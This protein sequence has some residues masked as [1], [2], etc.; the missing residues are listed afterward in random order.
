MSSTKVKVSQSQILQSLLSSK[1]MRLLRLRDI[2]TSRSWDHSLP[3]IT[4]LRSFTDRHNFDSDDSFFE[5]FEK[6]VN[7]G[8][9]YKILQNAGVFDKDNTVVLFGGCLLDIILKRQSVINDFDLRLVG[10]EY[11]ND[12]S[13]CI[14]KAKEFVTSVFSYLSKEKD[15]VDAIKKKAKEDGRHVYVNGCD[16][17]SVIVSRCR[18]TVT[19]HI[20]RFDSYQE[21]ILQLTF[22]PSPSLETMLKACHPY[23]TRLA[24]KDGVVVLD[25]MA[26][27]CIESTCIVVNP[28]DFSNYFLDGFGNALDANDEQKEDH[29]SGRSVT[30]QLLRLI[31]YHESKGFDIIL[32]D[33]DMDKVPR[34]NLEYGADEVLPL[35]SLIVKYQNVDQNIINVTGLSL[36]KKLMQQEG[37]G[38]GVMVGGYV[39]ACTDN[40]GES[41]HHNIRCLVN[42]IYNSFKYV[43]QGERFDHVFDYVPLLTYRMVG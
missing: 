6:Q 16:L 24:V 23:C 15:E 21:T 10:E 36:P 30:S 41:I 38:A 37:N 2:G 39:S 28:S 33:L 42:N 3:T 5:I 25:E 11:M 18:S 17:Q 9:P 22:A 4:T 29:S 26:K 34:R 32:P 13:K 43:A 1:E 14:A 35:P 40:V 7:G 8:L 27:F 31:D 19:V 12:E 20:P